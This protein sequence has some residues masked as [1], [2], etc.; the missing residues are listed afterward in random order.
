MNSYTLADITPGMTESFTVTVTEAMM[1]AF[2]AVSGDNSPI[3]MDAEYAA[4]RNSIWGDD[5]LDNMIRQI[6]RDKHREFVAFGRL[7]KG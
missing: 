4:G 1:D 6:D 7:K 2:Y 3:H 5:E